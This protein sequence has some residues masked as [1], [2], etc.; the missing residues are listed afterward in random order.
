MIDSFIT[1][2]ADIGSFV[3]PVAALFYEIFAGLITGGAGG[4]FDITENDLVAGIRFFAVIAM[5]AKV[6]SIKECTLVVPVT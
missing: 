1:A 6:M 3:Q 4:T 5:D 2:I